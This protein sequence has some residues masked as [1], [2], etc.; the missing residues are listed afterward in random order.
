V[1]ELPSGVEHGPADLRRR[2]LGRAGTLHRA[3]VGTGSR[4]LIAGDDQL[5]LLLSVL[6]VW[7][8]GGCAALVDPALS[9]RELRAA[10][11][12]V[13]P[14]ALIG[15][16]ASFHGVAG[17]GSRALS[18]RELD[19]EPA[20]HEPGPVRGLDPGTA[21]LIL[22][23]SGSSGLP[24]GVVLG[25]GA[26]DARLRLNLA[27]MGRDCLQR[28]LCVLP[29]H[30]GHGLIGG[31]LTPWLHGGHLHLGVAAAA[32]TGR[33][34]ST[35][36]D[37]HRITFMSS[38][39]AQWR[40][41]LRLGSSPAGR[42]LRRV[43]VGSAPLSATLWHEIIEWSGCADVVNVFGMTELANWFAGASAAERAPADGLVGWPWG[44][45]AA[46]VDADGQRQTLGEGEL[47]I[48]SPCAMTGYLDDA[49]RTEQVL[50]GGWLRSGDRACIDARDGIR[51]LGR[52]D[53]VINRAGA[54]VY[55]EELEMVLESHPEVAECCAF[56]VPEE[57]SGEA[58]AVA[59]RMHPGATAQVA[60]LT[61]WCRERLRRD[62]VATRWHLVQ[63]LPRTS[64]GKLS[65]D[66]VREACLSADA[67]SA[68]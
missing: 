30:F 58:V 54:K 51:L 16:E 6:A 67:G 64:R 36:L 39:P 59:V 29:V 14:T 44:G 3:G 18:F 11:Q 10:A 19:R 9:A 47:V 63:E 27:H 52:D 61:H 7:R 13:A 62:A 38:V 48:R 17:A 20:R 66:R 50:R 40:I 37:R 12:A 28:S 24:K 26:V 42:S 68:P 55:P 32:Q 53:H 60:E 1:T 43:H 49:A 8:L 57:L 56:S 41:A 4:V 31:C 15:D 35:W 34:L 5:Q 23:T 65:R 2:I 21:A 33:S 45:A 25:H 22:F 46:I